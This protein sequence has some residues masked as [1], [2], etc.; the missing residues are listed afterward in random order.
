MGSDEYEL[1]LYKTIFPIIFQQNDIFIYTQDKNQ[2]VMLKK[3]ENFK[4]VKQCQEADFLFGKKFENLPFECVDKPIFS[5]SYR[6]FKNSKNSFGAFYWRK[7]RPQIRFNL[8]VIKKYHL[9]LS[10]DLQKYAK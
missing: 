5:T 2:E 7:G 4:L 10:K 3:S 8:E 1:E 6:S 9:Y